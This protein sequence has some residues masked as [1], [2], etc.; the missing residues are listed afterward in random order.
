MA[1]KLAIASKLTSSGKDSGS[2]AAARE[3]LAIATISAASSSILEAI[4]VH[5]CTPKICK[6]FLA[7][8]DK[9]SNAH[10]YA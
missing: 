1:K 2:S 6:L 4:S 3:K 9:Y 5:I 8:K 10:A 7:M